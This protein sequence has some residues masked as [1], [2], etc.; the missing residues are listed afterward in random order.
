MPTSN[1]NRPN[2]TGGVERLSLAAEQVRGGQ[3]HFPGACTVNGVCTA[4]A[5]FDADPQQTSSYGAWNGIC[6]E[7]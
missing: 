5:C 7:A 4:C 3:A 6:F 1:V 2:S